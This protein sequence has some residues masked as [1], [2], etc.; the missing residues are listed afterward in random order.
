[1][2]TSPRS[3]R[4][5]REVQRRRRRRFRRGKG[6]GAVSSAARASSAYAVTADGTAAD[7]DLRATSGTRAYCSREQ[8]MSVGAAGSPSPAR[9]SRFWPPRPP[10][11]PPTGRQRELQEPREAPHVGPRRTIRI[12]KFGKMRN[13]ILLPKSFTLQQLSRVVTGVV[14]HAYD[15]GPVPLAELAVRMGGVPKDDF[16]A[17]IQIAGQRKDGQNRLSLGPL[18]GGGLAVRA[19]RR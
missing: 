13:E 3:P 14:R 5:E 12:G 1:M 16:L 9:P 8:E 15:H 6:L 2:R 19:L 4:R 11:S 10:R 18:V 17:A 7:V